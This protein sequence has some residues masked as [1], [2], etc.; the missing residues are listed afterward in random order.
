MDR[1][2]LADIASGRLSV[3]QLAQNFDD[4][5]PPLDR[6][7]ALIAAQRCY[8]CYDAPCIQACPTGID[9]PSFIRRITTDNLRGAAQDILGA[10]VLGGMCARVCPTEILCEGSCVRNTGE[11]QPVQIGALQ[12]YATD[13][14]FDSNTALFERAAATG[15]RVAVVGAGPAGLSCAHALARAGHDVVIF[16][17]KPRPGGLNEYGIAEYKVLD[18]AARE[19]DWLL[20]LGGI[21]WEG[22][23]TLGDDLHLSELR[24]DYDAVYL[25]LGLTGVNA[26]GIEGEALAG[27]RNAVDFIADLRQCP[28]LSKLPV[29]RRVVV[30]GGGNTAIDAAVQSKKLGAESVTLVY[31]RGST[32]MS[33]T[34]AEQEFAKTQGVSVIEWAQPRRILGDAA[35]A[36]IEFEYTQ[37]DDGGRLLGSGDCFTLAADSVLKAIGQTLIAPRTNG[38][39][40]AV[41][42]IR[43]GRIAVNAEFET[44][45]RGVWAGG[46]CVGGKVD[47]TVQS[48]EDGKLAA[49]A[50]HA[51]LVGGN[52][53]TEN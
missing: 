15:K 34:W 16:D 48:V 35:V 29:G 23:R 40:S 8:Y 24:R 14:V 3:Q 31:R 12:R 2:D 36:A 46:D 44:S 4:V 47:L 11:S 37:L 25:G 28:D 17:A 26:L 32:S 49:R 20:S 10:N 7:S 18:F 41:I 22:G 51:R 33:A 43:S 1:K 9:I 21:R 42:E 50:I 13:W 52:G 39:G 27:V 5:A 38:D 53:T 45:V 19:I 30:I 6:Q